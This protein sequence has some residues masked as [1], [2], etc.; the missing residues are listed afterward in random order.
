MP[1]PISRR[2]FVKHTSL[3]TGSLLP[4]SLWIKPG[5]PQLYANRVTEG[6]VR[7]EAAPTVVGTSLAQRAELARQHQYDPTWLNDDLDQQTV[8]LPAY[9]IDRHPVTNAQYLAFTQATK[10]RKPWPGG[11]FP[12][13]Q[14]DHPVV[15][16]GYT[17]AQAYA[18]WVGKRLPTAPEWEVAAQTAP[19]GLYPWGNQWP[20]PAPL[21]PT[22]QVPRWDQPPI[23]AV[24]S[25][26]HGRS[27]V[28]LEDF[29]G[30]VCEWTATTTIHH[31][32]LF[33]RLKG[34]SWVHRDPVSY[35]LNSAFWAMAGYY[36]PWIGFRCALEGTKIPSAV[37]QLKPVDG[38]APAALPV[39]AVTSG[40]P[41]VHRVSEAPAAVQQHL[42]SWSRLFLEGHRPD[43]A[44]HARGFVLHTPAM[45]PSPVCL[46]LAETL[47]WNNQALLAGLKTTDPL[48]KAVEG[49]P[50]TT[51]YT[52]DLTPVSVHFAFV[53]G[54]DY[55][56]LVTTVANKTDQSGVYETSSCFSL[57]SHP[58]FYDCEGQR[59]YVLTGRD[60][61]VPFRQIAR[62][63]EC[64][65]WIAPSDFSRQGGVPAQGVMAAVSRDGDWTFASV[66]REPG[67]PF[68]VS[69]NTWLNC[70]HTDAPVRID[71]SGK[72]IIEHR[73]YFL[74][75]GLER[76]RER[77]LS[78]AGK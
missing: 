53:P 65:R 39:A 18:R 49:S 4:F 29:T 56:D 72:R 46:F 24:G 13:Q 36:T 41:Q 11:T 27:R 25:G 5:E 50:G 73:L 31:D 52:L 63:G 26:K 55:V 16:V 7:V 33:S 10:A 54:P 76:L 14:A 62:L 34:A 28:G 17:E 42:L 48:L 6:M 74:R 19:A 2:S 44:A 40:G 15:G 9:W 21:Q 70:F 12:T 20:G 23:Q 32:V 1:K 71:A 66:R 38:V 59:T 67:A 47:T 60:E 61:L 37:P 77:L 35:R 75:G 69:G 30:Q 3:A 78:D 64:I 51:A 8:T 57:T 43:L 45:G 58:A 68:R 22:N